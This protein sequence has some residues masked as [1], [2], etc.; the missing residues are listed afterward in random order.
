VAGEGDAAVLAELLSD[1]NDSIALGA[2]GTLV[3][4]AAADFARTRPSIP[5]EK[6]LD[7]DVLEGTSAP[8]VRALQQVESSDS[9]ARARAIAIDALIEIGITERAW[10]KSHPPVAQE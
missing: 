10:R 3:A 5:R 4:L 8:S 1:P 9:G 2:R 6:W 7:Q